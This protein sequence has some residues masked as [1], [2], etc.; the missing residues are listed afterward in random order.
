[1]S[2]G[3]LS[4]VAMFDYYSNVLMSYSSFIPLKTPTWPVRMSWLLAEG[5]HDNSST[6]WGQELLP[7]YGYVGRVKGQCWLLLPSVLTL[8]DA[9]YRQHLLVLPCASYVND[10]GCYCQQPHRL[11]ILHIYWR[12]NELKWLNSGLAKWLLPSTCAIHRQQL[13]HKS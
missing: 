12:S 10:W 4:S 5:H 9:C 13:L 6:S 7:F 8:P 3:L 2:F 11:Q 1:M